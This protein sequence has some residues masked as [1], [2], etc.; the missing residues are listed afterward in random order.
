ML[1]A[2][3]TGSRHAGHM[4]PPLRQP[5]YPLRER[6]HA[7]QGSVLKDRLACWLKKVNPVMHS[8]TFDKALLLSVPRLIGMTAGVI[9][10]VSAKR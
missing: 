7:L 4:V 8:Q 5:S 1:C 10:F 3:E 6:F 9:E 2:L